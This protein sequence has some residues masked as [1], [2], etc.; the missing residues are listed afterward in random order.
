MI[1]F[2]KLCLPSLLA[3]TTGLLP[4]IAQEKPVEKLVQR[5]PYLA[6]AT[7]TS[8][9]IVWRTPRAIEARIQ[10][11][12]GGGRV[13][14]IVQ[15][16]SIKSR[17]VGSDKDSISTAP[18][19]TVQYEAIIT[20]LT[21]GKKYYY[22]LFDG[23]TRIAG[24][25]ASYF[26]S[27][28]PKVGTKNPFRFWVVGDSG[29]GDKV[30]AAVHSAMRT[31]VAQQKR[32]LDFYLHVGDM[33]YSTGKDEEFQHHFFEPYDQTLRNT[34][35]W[36]SMGNHEGANS[37]GKTGVGPYYDAYVTPTRGEAG[38]LASGTEA[39]YS[40]NYGNA[41][42]ICL[43][44]HDLDRKPDA[45][46]ARWLKADLEATR[47]D[48]IVAYWH[49]PPYTKGSHD[50]DTEKQ[51]IEMREH[52]MPILESG[53]VDLVLTGHSHIY[54]R[55]MLIDGAYNTPTV[56][57]NFVLDDG[58]GDPIGDGAY[59]KSA[60]L[61]PNEGE[62]QVVAGHGGTGLKRAGTHPVMKRVFVEHGSVIVDV[63]GDTLTAIMLNSE[64]KQRD[65]FSIIKRGKVTPQ[66]IAKP[67]QLPPFVK[68]DSLASLKL[69]PVAPF[70]GRTQAT[71]EIMA[72]PDDMAAPG[73]KAHIEWDTTGTAWTIEPKSAAVSLPRGQKLQVPFTL[74]LVGNY[75]P[76]PAAKI[77][78]DLAEP[79]EHAEGEEEEH[80]PPKPVRMPITVLPYQSVTAQPMQAAPV[81]DGMLSEQELAGLTKQSNL[82]TYKGTGLANYQTEFYTGIIDGKLYLAIVNHEPGMAKMQLREREFDGAL[83]SDDSSEIFLQRPGAKDHYQLIIN[84]TGQRY[85][86][87]GTITDW[88]GNW[89]TAVQ[90]GT[91]RWVS[92][93]LISLDMLGPLKPG[94]TIRFNLVRNNLVQGETSQW[95]HTNRGGNHR[96]EYFGTIVLGGNQ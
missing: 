24:G 79:E 21:P 44:S 16:A 57:E 35:C 7:P 56:A 27:T 67:K 70:G 52:I 32:P 10:V 41:H 77:T 42:F 23:K 78:Y 83:Y 43:N 2:S 12:P 80:E 18:P 4:A 6:T 86:S 34:V 82:I 14:R 26:F 30:Q 46:M 58:D 55:S 73:S 37:N 62:V 11:S 20:N 54:E 71:L 36:P 33:A 85:D 95:S 39:Y 60:G 68:V 89:T 91:D 61:H 66:R 84:A 47:A 72:I 25:D 63:K 15:G 90:R 22:A 50:S 65:L 9:T 17:T 64:G 48:W 51:L 87:R 40:F 59:R 38:G 76:L 81:I 5:G 13:G 19:G 28:H 96:P 53:G 69:G 31:F 8:M 45:A 1:R 88:N 94:D 75:F 3:L 93:S 92:E 74:L 29:T 49:H